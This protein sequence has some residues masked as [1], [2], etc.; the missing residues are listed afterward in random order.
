MNIIFLADIKF[1]LLKVKK[2]IYIKT[3]S[4]KAVICN[5]AFDLLRALSLG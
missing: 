4:V 3:L 1:R 5:L 2:I